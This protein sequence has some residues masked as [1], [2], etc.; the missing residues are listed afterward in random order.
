MR[1]RKITLA[2][3]GAALLGLPVLAAADGGIQGHC[4]DCHT[5]HNSVVNSKVAKTGKGASAYAT[6]ANQNLLKYDCLACHAQGGNSK[7]VTL[8][9]GSQVPQVYHKDA[10]GDLAGGNFAYLDDSKAGGKGTGVAVNRRGHNVADLFAGG[11]PTGG[12]YIRPPGMYSASSH[13]SAQIV[14]AG[15]EDDTG[16]LVNPAQP[17]KAFTCA[18]A[19]GCHG[20]RNQMI[21]G[22]TADFDNN[23]T[24]SFK[25][26]RRTGIAAITGAHHMNQDGLKNPGQNGQGQHSGATVAAGYRFIPG[27]KGKGNLTDRWQNVDGTSH[28]EYFGNPTTFKPSTCTNCHVDGSN[29][30][31]GHLGNDS[32]LMVPNQ[33]MT[34]FCSTCHSDFHSSGTEN[35]SSGAFLRHPSDY[36]IKNSGEYAN[37]VD[38]VVTAP[39]ARPDLANIADGSKVAKGVSGD[40]VMCLSCHQA[41][42]TP[43]PGMLRF[44]YQAAV[45]EGSTMRAGDGGEGEGCLACHTRKG[46]PGSVKP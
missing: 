4:S 3:A 30:L 45:L 13:G 1:A 7:I 23:G 43:Y 25:A 44:N 10:T 36:R 28:N 39:V 26:V 16:P 20:T 32:T 19:A 11:D 24:N 38:Y 35:G 21:S 8:T 42:A 31:K 15:V 27:L 2:L 14:F 18:G 37:Y 29:M 5:M 34:G 22:S 41:H 46:Y 33:S 17:F 40:M 12:N 9:G 6:T